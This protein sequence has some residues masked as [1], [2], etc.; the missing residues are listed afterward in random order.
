MAIAAERFGDR[1][2]KTDLPR[3][4]G[5]TV[6]TRHL[7]PYRGPHHLEGIKTL[8]TCAD[9]RGRNNRSG[10]PSVVIAHVHVFDETQGVS[11]VAAPFGKGQDLI[12]IQP[13]LDH[14]VDLH[15]KSG[16]TRGPDTAENMF[17]RTICA[18]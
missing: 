3:P 16:A 4:V 1:S 18:G 9:L 10:V 12:F 13:S 15:G 14:T 5:I 6:S 8:E 7:S 11:F 2:D 17:H